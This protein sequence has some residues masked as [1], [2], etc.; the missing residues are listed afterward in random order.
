MDQIAVWSSKLL[1]VSW[2][3]VFGQ[4]QPLVLYIREADH[5]TFTE[6]SADLSKTLKMHLLNVQTWTL[7]TNVLIC[8]N[9]TDN[10]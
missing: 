2:V 6:V 10:T 8:S 9:V 1:L 7:S 3:V 4:V 5:N